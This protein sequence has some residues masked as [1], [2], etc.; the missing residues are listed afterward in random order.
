MV[1]AG[2]LKID[3]SSNRN[4]FKFEKSYAVGEW[5]RRLYVI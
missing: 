2:K 1:E 4:K 3:I 5:G